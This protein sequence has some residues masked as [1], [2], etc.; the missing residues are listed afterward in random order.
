MCGTSSETRS[1]VRAA[2]RTAPTSS[3][4]SGSSS[5]VLPTESTSR[6]SFSSVAIPR[7][8][9]T[10]RARST[11]ARSTTL[12]NR[13]IR[14]SVRPRTRISRSGGR[15]STVAARTLK[16]SFSAFR[17]IRRARTALRGCSWIARRTSSPRPTTTPRSL[18][19]TAFPLGML[20]GGSLATRA[21]S[22]RSWFS[23]P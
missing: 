11:K 16:T 9:T 1:R 13:R 19:S 23:S 17:P 22:R 7:T 14:S 3:R 10:L 15:T 8:T 20:C 2:S 5:G 4:I 18:T 12:S 21:I 6:R